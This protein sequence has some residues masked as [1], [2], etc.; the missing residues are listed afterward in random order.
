MG[1]NAH[2]RTGRPETVSLSFSFPLSLLELESRKELSGKGVS[3]G[4]LLEK[5]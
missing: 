1:R 5:W 2:P 3:P 4:G